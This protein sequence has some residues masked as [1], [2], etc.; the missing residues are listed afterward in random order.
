MVSFA[1]CM[2]HEIKHWGT[3][4]PNEEGEETLRKLERTRATGACHGKAKRHPN[5]LIPYLEVTIIIHVNLILIL[6]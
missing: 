5:D 4:P 6:I 3:F 2:I 1:T